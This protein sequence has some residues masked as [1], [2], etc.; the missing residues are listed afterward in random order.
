MPYL[1]SPHAAVRGNLER[2]SSPRALFA[3]RY[4]ES[5][6]SLRAAVMVGLSFLP[7]AAIPAGNNTNIPLAALFAVVYLREL[8]A[9]PRLLLPLLI[10]VLTPVL[11]LFL[12]LVVGYGSHDIR[13]IIVWMV[14]VVPFGGIAAAVVTSP[15]TVRLTVRA[16]ILMAA[17]Y[18]II[19]KFF[20]DNGIIPFLW[21]Y[22]IPGYWSVTENADTITQFVRRPFGWFPESSFMAGTLALAAMAL[23]LLSYLAYQRLDRVDVVT[24]VAAVAAMI[25]G[26]SGSA[27]LTVPAL[28]A[29][30]F[31]PYSTRL[32]RAS[33]W[34]LGSGILLFLATQLLQLRN[35]APNHSWDDRGSS[36]IAGLRFLFD[37]FPSLVIGVGPGGANVLFQNGKIPL[38]GLLVHERLFDIFSV[39]GRVLLE[40]GAIA[41]AAMILALAVPIVRAF[42]IGLS[43]VFGLLALFGWLAVVTLTIS[44]S[45][46]AWLWVFPGIC[47]GVLASSLGSS[48]ITH[49]GSEGLGPMNGNSVNDDRRRR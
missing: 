27:L 24:V 15:S 21:M 45:S 17:A 2:G 30:M 40:N 20:L 13:S 18:T 22:N 16:F 11:M 8:L 9:R 14:D 4:D 6:F 3:R 43:W 26:E 33:F 12:Q 36:I 19:Q 48:G 1:I 10:V 31:L 49:A 23:F 29:M 46:A 47:L 34:I 28:A 25:L 5:V 37:S 42:T 41:G 32:R 39:S 38:D 35:S 44:Y 7:Y